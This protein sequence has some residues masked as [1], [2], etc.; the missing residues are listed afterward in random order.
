MAIVLGRAVETMVAVYREVQVGLSTKTAHTREVRS[1]LCMHHHDGMDAAPLPPFAPSVIK[2]KVTVERY[3]AILLAVC[4]HVP[5]IKGDEAWS[6][7]ATYA[8]D[9]AR[10]SGPRTPAERALRKSVLELAERRVF[11]VCARSRD[12]TDADSRF[13]RRRDR[14]RALRPRRRVRPR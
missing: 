9:E 5:T 14:R 1:R 6:F 2:A 7:I 12:G 3:E 8:A 11:G 4:A 13:R 10:H